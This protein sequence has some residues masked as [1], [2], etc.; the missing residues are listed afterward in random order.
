[1][2][3]KEIIEKAHRRMTLL[4]GDK[5][6]SYDNHFVSLPIIN[7]FYYEVPFLKESELYLRS[8]Y[9]IGQMRREASKKGET[10]L[11]KGVAATS[12]IG[13]LLG[14]NDINPLPCHTYCPRCKNVKFTKQNDLAFENCYEKCNC[15]GSLVYDGY[16][17]SFEATSKSIVEGN[18][19]VS[20]STGFFD[21]ASEM[22]R[23]YP[24]ISLFSA[25]ILDKCREM[26]QATGVSLKDAR[27][28]EMMNV[29]LALIN[30]DID[31]NPILDNEFIKELIAKMAPVNYSELLKIIG[32]AHGTNIWSR[33]ADELFLERRMKLADIPVFKDDL[34][35]EISKRLLSTGLF[36]YGLANEVA[37]KTRR[38][39]YA[40]QGNV[41]K[42]TVAALFSLGF[43]V[44]FI[45]FI[46][47]VNYMFPKHHVIAYLKYAIAFMWYK[48][49]FAK[50]FDKVMR[51]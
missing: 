3:K 5:V 46:E 13:F 50:E 16:G 24:K 20:V 7:R 37:E 17:I 40:R 8:L 31:G 41:D 23:E 30:G 22:L 15:G 45:F 49:H 14:A 27:S 33:N 28:D 35:V 12:F 48:I 21:E 2:K 51:G 9:Q 34:Y 1:M 44:D 6:S 19:E 43:D 47:R 25:P 38:G 26:A 4:Y 36:E 11:I 18:I 39:Y 32:M 29:F 42:E 10:I